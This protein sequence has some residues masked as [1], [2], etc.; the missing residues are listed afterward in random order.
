MK[1][2]GNIQP[3]VMDSKL[4]VYDDGNC[5]EVKETDIDNINHN[6]FVLVDKYNIDQV[7]LAGPQSFLKGIK[8]KFDL[9]QMNK[10][11]TKKV[12]M[13]LI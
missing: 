9:A 6:I 13:K 11:D 8:D 12:N 3:F 5:V 7:D 2:V 4:Y 10:Y 1:I